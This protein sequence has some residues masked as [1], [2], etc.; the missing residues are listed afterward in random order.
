MEQKS[1][2]SWYLYA[3]TLLT[4][5]VTSVS[6]QRP[7]S[8]DVSFEPEPHSV[9]AK[10]GLTNTRDASLAVSSSGMLSLLSV[11]ADSTGN[12]VGYAMSHDGGDSFM[13]VVPVSDAAAKVSSHGESAPTLATVP[14]GIYVLWQ[15]RSEK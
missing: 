7:S 12:H 8:H 2:H 6:C 15:Q 5:F 4:L 1:S 3:I 11:Y 9:L 13:P 14:D 10:L